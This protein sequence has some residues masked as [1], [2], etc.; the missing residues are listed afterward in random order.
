MELVVNFLLR[1]TVGRRS[2]EPGDMA[3][4][5]RQMA[6]NVV[7]RETRL[8]QEMSRLQIEIDEARRVRQVHEFT[9]TDYFQN[10]KSRAS[11]LRGRSSGTEG[12]A[13]DSP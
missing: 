5:F 13:T 11:E 12:N 9:S 8:M 10:L 1:Q 4:V 6:H 2:D 7:R 3:R